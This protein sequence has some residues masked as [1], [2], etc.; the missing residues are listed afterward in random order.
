MIIEWPQ[1]GLKRNQINSI[2]RTSCTRFSIGSLCTSVLMAWHDQ[3]FLHAPSTIR[4]FLSI[5][6]TEAPT[7]HDQRA[8]NQPSGTPR[9]KPLSLLESCSLDAKINFWIMVHA[10]ASIRLRKTF[11]VPSIVPLCIFKIHLQGFCYCLQPLSKNDIITLQQNTNPFIK[12]EVIRRFKC[13]HTFI[14]YNNCGW[15]NVVFSRFVFMNTNAN[16]VKA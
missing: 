5:S 6:S 10:Q 1:F 3:L 13:K 14:R 16:L 9:V 8:E 4:F 7:L 12:K 15:W 11:V 2:G